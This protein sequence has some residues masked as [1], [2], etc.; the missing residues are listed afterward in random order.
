VLYRHLEL[1][2]VIFETE[3]GGRGIFER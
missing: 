2:G 3:L 1:A